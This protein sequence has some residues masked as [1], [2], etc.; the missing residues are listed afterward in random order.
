MTKV[1]SLVHK[2]RFEAV[3]SMMVAGEMVL[4]VAQAPPA[5]TAV[6]SMSIGGPKQSLLVGMN[7]VGNEEQSV[8]LAQPAKCA[9]D[10]PTVLGI[11]LGFAHAVD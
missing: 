4:S 5:G 6:R 2:Q 11:S 10:L 7:L 3:I 1:M 8:V 9:V